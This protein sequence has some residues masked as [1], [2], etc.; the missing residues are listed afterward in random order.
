MTTDR[1][2]VSRQQVLNA[3]TRELTEARA[4]TTLTR[5]SP[6]WL[7]GTISPVVTALF[8]ELARHTAIGYTTL[9]EHVAQA[10]TITNNTHC[11]RQRA[12][13]LGR[14]FFRYTL[15]PLLTLIGEP[16]AAHRLAHSSDTTS[17]TTEIM[18]RTCA[19]VMS[20]HLLNPDDALYLLR[21]GPSPIIFYMHTP[22]N[23]YARTHLGKMIAQYLAY[24]ADFADRIQDEAR[25]TTLHALIPA[26]LAAYM[27]ALDAVRV[28]QVAPSLRLVAPAQHV[29]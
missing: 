10:A 3:I 9:H 13:E 15:A 26:S 12:I 17:V 14:A 19:R 6:E 28:T 29:A 18:D 25:A 11:E 4:K 5:E 2:P 20:A 21:I 16:D 24:L 22:N 7:Y 1:T 8:T 27:T 23:P